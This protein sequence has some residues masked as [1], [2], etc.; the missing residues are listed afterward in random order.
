MHPGEQTAPVQPLTSSTTTLEHTLSRRPSWRSKNRREVDAA[1][2]PIPPG[3]KLTAKTE[4]K[5]T[6][7]VPR[8]RPKEQ[9]RGGE[10][11][12]KLI[13]RHAGTATTK[14][15]PHET[16]LL[17]GDVAAIS[18]SENGR[19]TE[20]RSSRIHPYKLNNGVG[21]VGAVAEIQPEGRS[22]ITPARH[23]DLP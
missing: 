15:P 13:R 11:H 21:E 17:V 9:L 3:N 10:N 19:S 4:D 7:L 12:G 23:T 16:S 18:T 14:A 8:R 5:L 22:S 1:A 2:M 6:P 20:R